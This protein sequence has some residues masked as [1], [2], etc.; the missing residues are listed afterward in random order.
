MKAHLI[1]SDGALLAQADSEHP[2][3]GAQPTSSW[4]P[5]QMVRDVHDFHLP[6]GADL[7]SAHAV[8]GLYQIVGDRFPSLAEIEIDV[9]E[10]R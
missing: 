4:Q 3:R 2:V 10:E 7:Q 5:G 1:G 9:R 8:V 6:S